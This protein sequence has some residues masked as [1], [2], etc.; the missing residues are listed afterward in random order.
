V[1]RVTATSDAAVSIGYGNGNTEN[2]SCGT[3]S[4]GTQQMYNGTTWTTTP[5]SGQTYGGL[6]LIISTDPNIDIV[7]TWELTPSN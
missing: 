6:K 4:F 3:I 5:E 1:T 2:S 7:H